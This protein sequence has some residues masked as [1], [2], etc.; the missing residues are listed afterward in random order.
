MLQNTTQ[1]N[2]IRIFVNNLFEGLELQNRV[3]EI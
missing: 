3:I 2:K 1:K